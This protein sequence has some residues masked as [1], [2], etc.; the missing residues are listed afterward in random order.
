VERGNQRDLSSS[1][2]GADDHGE[3]GLS[4]SEFACGFVLEVQL[5][6]C[7]KQ[8]YNHQE[9]MGL[10]EA[11]SKPALLTGVSGREAVDKLAISMCE[12]PSSS[13]PMSLSESP[14]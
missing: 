9:F 8:G 5:Q 11:A 14:F 12:S 4:V 13:H 6:L 10:E 7:R 2:D 1:N 3:A